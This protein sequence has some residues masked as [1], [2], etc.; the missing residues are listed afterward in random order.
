MLFYMCW[1]GWREQHFTG[2]YG[3]Q[4]IDLKEH[5]IDVDCDENKD[6]ESR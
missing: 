3:T 5:A 6:L 2:V 4:L 1:Y